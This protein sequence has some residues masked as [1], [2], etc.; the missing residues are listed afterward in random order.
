MHKKATIIASVV[1]L[2]ALLF[3]V[4]YAAHSIN[5]NS[6]NEQVVSESEI[7]KI[8]GYPSIHI[9]YDDVGGKIDYPLIDDSYAET[10]I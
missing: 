3:F 4:G 10:S 8:L 7:E 9:Y 1:L 6:N 2:S 5:G